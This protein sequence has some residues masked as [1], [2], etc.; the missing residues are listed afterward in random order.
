M[1]QIIVKP[2]GKKFNMDYLDVAQ[3]WNED[4][5]GVSWWENGALETFTTMNYDRFKTILVTLDEVPAVAHMRNTTRGITCIDNNHPF[6]IPSGKMFHNG[7]I[8]GL[9]ST[10]VVGSDTEALAQLITDCDYNFIEDLLPLIQQ[11][12]GKTLNKLVFFEDNGRITFVNKDLGMEEDGIWYSNDYHKKANKKVVTYHYNNW[13]YDEESESYKQPQLPAKKEELTKVFVYGTLKRGFGNHDNYLK[14]A[15][16]LGTARTVQK[17]A[18]IG[19]YMA[20]PY[21][22]ERDDIN[23]NIITGQVYEVNAKQLAALDT[24]EGVP[25]HYIKVKASV[26]YLG[27]RPTEEVYMY[28]KASVD[29]SDRE[30]PYITEFKGMTLSKAQRPY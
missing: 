27:S 3:G 29:P 7:T 9:T 15:P 30:R 20:F 25:S 24:L 4:G 18:M 28:V 6:D 22:L 8:Y 14:G 19:Q 10:N 16:C 5:Y 17:W 13:D 11:I 12:V 21:V 2:E 1:C 26:F 23:G